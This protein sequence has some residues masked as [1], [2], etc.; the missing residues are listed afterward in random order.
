LKLN[1]R[2]KYISCLSDRPL[3]IGAYK[4]SLFSLVEA[5]LIPYSDIDGDAVTVVADDVKAVGLAVV[6]VGY[7]GAGVNNDDSVDQLG[8]GHMHMTA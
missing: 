2:E 6:A 1:R 8:E 4:G 3:I 7:T 5:L